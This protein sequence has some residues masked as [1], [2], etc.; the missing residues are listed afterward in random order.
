M[1]EIITRMVSLF[2]YKNRAKLIVR[3]AVLYFAQD[4]L[5]ASRE[6]KQDLRIESYKTVSGFVF[7]LYSGINILKIVK[8]I[9]D[10][11]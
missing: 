5:V 11:F 8:I 6:C 10:N 3:R 4:S 1:I 2:L 9:L 7:I